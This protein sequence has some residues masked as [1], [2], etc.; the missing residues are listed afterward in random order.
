MLDNFQWFPIVALRDCRK[1]F[2]G[3]GHSDGVNLPNLREVKK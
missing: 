1:V 3:E 2:I